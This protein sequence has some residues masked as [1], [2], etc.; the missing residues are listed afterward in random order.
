[1]CTNAS[2]GEIEKERFNIFDGD[3]SKLPMHKSE[4][5]YMLAKPQEGYQSP[6]EQEVQKETIV[7]TA[8]L[9]SR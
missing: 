7:L 9:C 5:W 3:A 2:H 6:L 8:K 1:M 4:W